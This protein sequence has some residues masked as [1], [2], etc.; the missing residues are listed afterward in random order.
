MKCQF[1]VVDRPTR[2]VAPLAGAWIEMEQNIVKA[3]W[4]TLSLPSRERGLK[5]NLYNVELPNGEVAPLAGAWIE[6][7]HG[8]INRHRRLSLPSRERGLK[9]PVNVELVGKSDVAPLAGAWIEIHDVNAI[10]NSFS[11]APLAGAWIE[12]VRA[13]VLLASASLSLPSRERGLKWYKT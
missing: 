4:I 8:C 1:L 5:S 2:S 12:I 9:F 7:L 3:K 13:T 6:I 11:V 10:S